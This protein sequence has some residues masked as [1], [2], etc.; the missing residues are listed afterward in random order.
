M[1][2]WSAVDFPF[3]TIPST[4]IFSPGRTRTISLISTS[5]ANIR[6]SL[7]FRRT[8]ASLGASSTSAR[9]ESLALFAAYDSISSPKEKMTTSMAASSSN[10]K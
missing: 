3:T 7:P 9:M 5:S 2:D 6:I 10:P 8:V 4:G 1:E